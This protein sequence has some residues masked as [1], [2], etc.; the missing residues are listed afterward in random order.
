MESR[1]ANFLWGTHDSRP[2]RHW[3]SWKGIC[4]PTKENGLALR[5]I[6]DVSKAFSCKL[7]WKFFANQGIWAK[8][9]H[10]RPGGWKNSFYHRRLFLV[11][12]VFQDNLAYIVNNES[13]LFW[14]DNWSGLS[15][16]ATRSHGLLLNKHALVRDLYSPITG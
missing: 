4:Y 13:N 1:F 9:L 6:A 7:L 5:S 16:L 12:D 10:T 11:E 14:W 15:R 3:K 2:K 8:F